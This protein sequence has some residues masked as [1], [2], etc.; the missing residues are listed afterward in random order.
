MPEDWQFMFITYLH[1]FNVHLYTDM[2]NNIHTYTYAKHN[3]HKYHS[4]M[5]TQTYILPT[6]IYGL[7]C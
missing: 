1:M 6:H 3:V 5:H 2:H 7:T 4:H